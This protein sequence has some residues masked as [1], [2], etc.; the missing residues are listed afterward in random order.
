[1][2]NVFSCFV[3]SYNGD[4][5]NMPLYE[6]PHGDHSQHLCDLFKAGITV[7]EYKMLV[8]KGQFVCKQCGRV[9]RKEENLCDPISLNPKKTLI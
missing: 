5:L 1:M 8:D 9:A 3:I 7:A 2:K 6:K 4:E